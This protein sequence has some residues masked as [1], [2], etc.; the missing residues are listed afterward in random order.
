MATS[1]DLE[2]GLDHV[3]NTECV[4]SGRDAFCNLVTRAN[5]LYPCANKDKS[6]LKKIGNIAAYFLTEWMRVDTDQEK[7]EIH[8]KWVGIIGCLRG[9]D[10]RKVKKTFPSDKIRQ[11]MK[12]EMQVSGAQNLTADKIE[13]VLSKVKAFLIRENEDTADMSYESNDSDSD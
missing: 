12:S 3:V 9:I 13:I 10:N 5:Q 4:I 11:L 1:N 6:S 2:G 8:N 7:E